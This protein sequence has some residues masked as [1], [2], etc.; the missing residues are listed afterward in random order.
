MYT[1]MV[2][3]VRH[4]YRAV[5]SCTSFLVMSHPPVRLRVAWWGSR[6]TFQWRG[7]ERTSLCSNA[8]NSCASETDQP[9]DQM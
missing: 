4:R 9:M 7:T 1:G 8:R 6:G 2:C 5:G 3:W